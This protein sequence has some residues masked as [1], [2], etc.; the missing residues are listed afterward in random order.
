MKTVTLFRHAK[1]GDKDNPNL[2]DFDRPL[3]DRGLKA[4]PKMGAALRDRGVRPDLIL[5]S[6]SARTRQTLTLASAAAWDNPPAECFETKIYE[7][8][9]RTLLKLLRDCPE[10]VDHVMFVG[11]NPGLQDLAV[12]LAQ[13][14]SAER[15]AIKD[16]LPTAAIVSFAFDAE[17]WNDLEPGEGRVRLFITPNTLPPH[18]QGQE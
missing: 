5:C 6:P 4:A 3:S 1:S 14:G 8:G 17:A 18:G 2:D 7:A 16:K 10:D 15:H 12:T 11:H 9:E 13:P